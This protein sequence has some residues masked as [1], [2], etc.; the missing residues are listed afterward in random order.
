MREANVRSPTLGSEWSSFADRSGGRGRR[1]VAHRR[2]DTVV[3]RGRQRATGVAAG[4]RCHDLLE[5]DT[6]VDDRQNQSPPY[7]GV[8]DG[9]IGD[10]IATGRPDQCWI[11]R[12]ERAQR[13]TRSRSS[14]LQRV[15]R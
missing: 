8:I 4:Y 9:R 13:P 6:H 10:G 5:P 11:V 7:D 12:Q 2:P 15:P 14:V 1:G 3:G